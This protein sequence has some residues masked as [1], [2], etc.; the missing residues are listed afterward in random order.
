MSVPPSLF[1]RELARMGI[2]LELG[3][4]ESGRFSGVGWSVLKLNIRR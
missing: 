2:L 4:T 1:S 3:E